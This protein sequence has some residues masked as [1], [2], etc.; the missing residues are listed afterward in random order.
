MVA[1][2]SSAARAARS[3][4]T[5]AR[6]GAGSCGSRWS[7]RHLSPAVVL[8]AAAFC[9]LVLVSAAWSPWSAAW[10]PPPSAL[11]RAVRRAAEP[12]PV[13]LK[14][15]EAAGALAVAGGV[16]VGACERPR[17]AG[18]EGRSRTTGYEVQ[19]AERDW[20]AR[21]SPG[22]YF[23]LRRGGT[24]QPGSSPLVKE[25]RVGTFAC[26]ACAAALFSSVEKFE[27]GTGWPSFADR[28]PGVEVE[29]VNPVQAA[30]LGAELRCARCGGHLGDV[31]SDGVL[32]LGTRAF[33]TGKRYCIDGAALVFS[34]ADGSAPALGEG[35]PQKPAELPEWLRPPGV[36]VS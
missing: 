20:A 29:D 15:R 12:P 17:R 32:F 5:C 6:T 24:E 31:F 34:P 19:R 22:E 14:R 33:E 2:R 4:R 23:V 21:L 25:K 8:L 1:L 7:L 16:L 13:A 3:A 26:A 27:S 30:L 9:G 18:A 35:P 11:R 28:M 10:A 36:R